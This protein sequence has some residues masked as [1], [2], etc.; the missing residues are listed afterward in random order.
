MIWL[1]RHA[2]AAD[3]HPDEA[4]PLTEK[5]ERQARVAGRALARLD[6]RLDACLSSPR[7]RALDTARLAC[8]PLGLTPTVADELDGDPFDAE[9]LAAGLG[10]VLL[11]GHNPSMQQAVHDLTGARTRFKKAAVAV[12]SDGEL[13]A[14]L[15]PRELAAIAGV[16][17]GP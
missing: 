8:E 9:R 17:A 6:V 1:L 10:Q 3:G 14:L 16:G 4:R 2:D 13:L 5:G 15:G 12:V 7:V 11:V